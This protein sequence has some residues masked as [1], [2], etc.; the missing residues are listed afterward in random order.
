VL[1]LAIALIIIG[2]FVGFLAFPFGF[3]PGLIGLVLLVIYAV[4]AVRRTRERPDG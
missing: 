3:L 2:I 1:G 4:S